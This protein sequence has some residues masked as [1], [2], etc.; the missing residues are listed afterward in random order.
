MGT[1]SPQRQD[2]PPPAVL[3]GERLSWEWK[4]PT[5]QATPQT[6]SLC[7]P[8]L[9][10]PGHRD[11][12]LIPTAKTA[13]S[14]VPQPSRAQTHTLQGAVRLEDKHVPDVVCVGSLELTISRAGKNDD[15]LLSV[16]SCFWDR[17]NICP[18]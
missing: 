4:E 5:P 7:S 2:T 6:F 8:Q 1:V 16:L 12:T 14:S 9:T 18:R 11:T 10:A 17:G 13:R 15:N 3:P